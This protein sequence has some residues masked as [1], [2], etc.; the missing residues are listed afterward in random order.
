MA[1][2]VTPSEAKGSRK[3]REA[4]ELSASPSKRPEARARFPLRLFMCQK[5]E[6]LLLRPWLKH[7][8]SLVDRPEDVRVVDDFSSDPDVIEALREAE[9]AGV[10]VI[11]VRPPQM[12]A[13]L[14]K[15]VLFT[16]WVME[17][18]PLQPA[19]YVPLDCDEFLSAR[20]RLPPGMAPETLRLEHASLTLNT[21][22]SASKDHIRAALQSLAVRGFGTFTIRR[23]R[24]FSHVPGLFS[25]IREHKWCGIN[26]KIV[27]FGSGKT[28][29]RHAMAIPDRGYHDVVTGVNHGRIYSL[30]L[31]EFHNMPYGERQ[32]KSMR[33]SGL[34]PSTSRTKYLT[35]GQ[36]SKAEYE[37]G[38]E[39]AA[40]MQPTAR[41]LDFA[42]LMAHVVF[43]FAGAKEFAELLRR[44]ETAADGG[45]S[46]SVTP[47]ASAKAP[48]GD[49]TQ[50]AQ[51][52]QT[53]PAKQ[54]ALPRPTETVTERPH[55]P[56]RLDVHQRSA[57]GPAAESKACGEKSFAVPAGLGSTPCS[58]LGL[59]PKS[60]AVPA[61][62][63][64]HRR[65]PLGLPPSPPAGSAEERS[66]PE[67]GSP[68]EPKKCLHSEGV[69]TVAGEGPM[70]ASEQ[71]TAAGA[72]R[73]FELEEDSAEP[74]E[75]AVQDE[76]AI[77]A[78]IELCFSDLT[79][80]ERAEIA[81]AEEAAEDEGIPEQGESIPEQGE[82]IP[83]QDEGIPEQGEGIP[84]Q[85]EGIPEQGEGIPEQ[86]EGIP[87][88]GKPTRPVEA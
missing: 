51:L 74:E 59:P 12:P 44:Q 77:R 16:R 20:G 19:Y 80:S 70:P 42:A 23:L 87:E 68:V 65:S 79:E 83:E 6:R 1:L 35:E 84:E 88:Q 52:A 73:D 67:R 49:S 27:V 43:D 24:N 10:Q 25:D 53:P 55:P 39:T 76:E 81:Q 75:G 4:K 47:K 29:L 8:L 14:R 3:S 72:A 22:L 57:G 60:F 11:W 36:T 64:F 33:M 28:V 45:A 40:H 32:S 71:P 17:F 15:N 13:F 82:G 50:L 58:P 37:R 26:R 7:A 31:V 85:G 5:N 9:A 54:H 46:P 18:S 61:G 38:Q 34:V 69:P 66:D 48:H 63:G 62:L 78:E 56:L 21:T 86:G 2:R 41:S 30:C